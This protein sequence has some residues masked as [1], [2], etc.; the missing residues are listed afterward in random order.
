MGNQTIF[1]SY[2]RK[3]SDFVL[4][5][6]KRLREAGANIW[7][8]QLDIEAGTNWD[9]SI[10]QALQDSD[11]LLVA[12]SK[13]SVLSNNVNDEFSYAL[14]EGKRVVPV[15]LEPCNIPFRLRRLQYADFSE[16]QEKGIAT[17]IDTLGL[18]QDVASNL[19]DSKGKLSALS[20]KK[21][22]SQKQGLS[23]KYKARI[24]IGSLILIAVVFGVFKSG[25][26]SATQPNTY[27][28]TV[29]VHD[30]SGKDQLVLPNRGQV[31]LI[32]GDASE[33]ETINA[34]GE[35]TFKQIPAHFFEEDAR[36][37]ILFYDP[38]GE[39]YRALKADTSY[40]LTS[41]KYIP[42]P[43]KL[44][45]LDQV[46]G[47]VKHF[48]TGDPITDARI[49]ISGVESFSNSY[50]EFNLTIPPDQQRK[51]QT[52]RAFKEGFEIYEL[53]NVPIQTDQELPIVLK[54]KQTQ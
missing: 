34:K 37:E 26:F 21:A 23:H 33:I 38:E 22:S 25:L 16:D 12:L 8:D 5:L 45:G 11:T 24:L 50:G 32:H 7:L 2:S 41:G 14:E 39:P 17:L 30:E 10:E 35:A 51:Y 44:F 46:R 43:V 19:S 42:L 18:S 3:D 47:I 1:F 53:S 52:V 13:T 49:S 6:G 36:V 28:L 9:D 20:K 4:E 48:V 40:V 15:L 29:L 31:K 54:P 27:Q